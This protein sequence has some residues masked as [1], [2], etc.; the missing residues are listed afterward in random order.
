MSD[1]L[2]NSQNLYLQ[3]LLA[4]EQAKMAQYEREQSERNRKE[5][6]LQ[7]KTIQAKIQEDAKK[8]AQLDK[9]AADKRERDALI[10]GYLN[11]DQLIDDDGID[12]RMTR[13]LI[14]HGRKAKD[15]ITYQRDSNK[16]QQLNNQAQRDELYE[17]SNLRW[18]DQN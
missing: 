6:E 17:Q 10:N 1:Q 16:N 12:G 2:N 8:K 3:Q 13:Q 15:S 5:K 9:L 7:D 11:T 18:W 4:L 14:S